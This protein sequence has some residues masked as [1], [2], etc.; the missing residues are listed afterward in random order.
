MKKIL[1]NFLYYFLSLFNYRGAVILLYHSVSENY[2]LATVKPADF[3]KHLE[4]KEKKRFNVIKLTELADLIK[5]RRKIPP[6]TVCLTFDD[7]C[8]DN[9]LNVFPL[10]KKYNFPAAIFVSTA[11]I[12]KTKLMEDGENFQYLSA[13]EITEMFKSGLV[14]FGSHSHNHLKLANIKTDRAE[15]E[16]LTSKKVLAQILGQEIISLA[17]PVGRFNQEVEKLARKNFEIICTV[18]KGRVTV[19]DAIWRLKRN[20][21]DSQ[22][23]FIQFKGIIKFGR[24]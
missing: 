18:K 2:E 16:M 5:N 21:I 15:T 11:L 17:Y 1:K 19:N 22:V 4:K 9:F 13:E 7:G 14:E 23:N 20:A 12:G 6:K 8:R 10:L 24:V 3:M